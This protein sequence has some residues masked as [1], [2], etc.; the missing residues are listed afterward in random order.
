MA[1]KNNSVLSL[2]LFV[3]MF[4]GLLE[5]VSAKDAA[6]FSGLPSFES[7]PAKISQS[8]SETLQLALTTK[9]AKRHKTVITAEAAKPVNFAGQYRIATWGCGTDCRGFA[10]INKQTGAVFTLPGVEYVAGVMGND[11]ERLSY[12]IDSN[13]FIITGMKND[14]ENEKGKFFYLWKKEKL[15]LL[16]N[17]PILEADIFAPGADPK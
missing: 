16:A 12:R 14:D 17:V 15:N 10:I 13:L 2:L 4:V 8:S 5:P 7:Y 6:N 1:A 9:L 11:E 3:G